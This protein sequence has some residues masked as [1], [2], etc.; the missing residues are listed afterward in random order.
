M[1]LVVQ[2][3]C[4]NEAQGLSEVIADVPRE[5]A[6]V[7]EVEILVID[8]GS[9]DGTA[10]A[11]RAAGVQH[12]LR[13]RRNQGLARV[14]VLGLSAAVRLGAD[15][16]VN[17]DADN[18]YRGV[19]IPRL[20]APILAGE[21]DMVIGD[22]EVHAVEHFSPSKRV[23]QQVGSWVVRKVSATDVPDAT[24]GFRALSREAALRMNVVTEFTYTLETIIQAGK[25]RLALRHVPVTTNPQKRP[26][27][28]FSNAWD[29]VKRSATSLL[30]IYTHYEPLKT[31]SIVGLIF[32]FAGVTIGVRFL[33]GYWLGFGQGRVQ[34]LILAAVLL[35]VGVQVVLIGLIGDTIAANRRLTEEILY[36]QRKA[37][38]RAARAEEEGRPR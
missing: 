32:F 13:L 23:L 11:A 9:T 17:F 6:G 14:F 4:L 27:R 34:S 26:S 12:I 19:D 38:E 28:L 8:D 24:S 22:R 18:Q 15:V 3:P 21:A 31:F 20:I 16:I 29:Y 1:K 25:Q 2:I 37:E 36:L 10:E 30:R 33:Y 35:I 7:D 5:I